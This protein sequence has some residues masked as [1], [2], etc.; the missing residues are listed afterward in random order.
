V[1]EMIAAAKKHLPMMLPGLE[2]AEAEGSFRRLI[3]VEEIDLDNPGVR[4]YTEHP[5]WIIG[6]GPRKPS[7]RPK[8]DQ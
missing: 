6:K 3:P 4:Q 5:Q 7:D 8:N 1:E 2:K